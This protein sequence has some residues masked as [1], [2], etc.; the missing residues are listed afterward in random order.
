MTFCPTIGP[1]GTVW[2]GTGGEGVWQYDP[3]DRAHSG[4]PFRQFTARDGLID[5][6]A[7]TTHFTADRALWIGTWRGVSRFDGTNFVNFTSADGLAGTV[8]TFL[9]SN[10]DGVLW[11]GTEDGGLSRYDPESYESYTVADGLAGNQVRGALR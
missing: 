9:G 1:D 11:F 2:F 5:A 4:S 10:S 8:A 3:A 7:T 6:D